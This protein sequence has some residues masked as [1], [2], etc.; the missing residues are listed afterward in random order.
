[1]P[2]RVHVDAV[3][4]G[5]IVISSQQ[6]HHLRAVLRLSDG[7]TVELFD[8]A[9]RVGTA[10]LRF[11]GQSAVAQVE[12]ITQTP[13]SQ[14]QLI[15]ASAL[16]K[17]NRAD[18]M[19]EKLSELG[20]HRFIPLIT[21]RTVV[22]A[23][24]KNKLE[25]FRRIATEAAQQSH[26]TGVLQ[27]ESVRPLETAL[28]TTEAN[29]TRLYCSTGPDAKPLSDTEIPSSGTLTIFI[30]PEGGWADEEITLFTAAQIPA[31][32]LGKTIL[33]IETAALAAAAILL[34][35]LDA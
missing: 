30:G 20:A 13:N 17:G 2:R 19:I 32:S 9:G 12:A 27:I 14:R 28:Q 33:R 24:G 3:V 34:A 1:M 16:P 4:P 8:D 22:L 7:A 31:V 23:E 35:H 5:E 29:E 21:R 26:R 6:A 10:N 25:R 15:I 18:W 11:T